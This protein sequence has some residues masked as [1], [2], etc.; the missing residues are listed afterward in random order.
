MMQQR[1]QP[2]PKIEET[3]RKLKPPVFM[4]HTT[5]EKVPMCSLSGFKKDKPKMEV[6]YTIYKAFN[7]D[8]DYKIYVY[9]GSKVEITAPNIT[10]I[11]FTCTQDSSNMVKSLK[12]KYSNV[13]Q[14]GNVITLILDSNTTMVAFTMSAQSRLSSMTVYTN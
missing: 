14:N 13:T 7:A 11:V 2:L 5:I 6:P 3:V 12:T 1:Q 9:S 4:Q 8:D 10:K